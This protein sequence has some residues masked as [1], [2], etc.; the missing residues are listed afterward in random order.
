MSRRHCPRQTCSRKLHIEL[1]K[2]FNGSDDADIN[3]AISGLKH[4]ATVGHFDVFNE[5]DL[6]R[7][8]PD[9]V[10]QDFTPFSGREGRNKFQRNLPQLCESAGEGQQ[11]RESTDGL[12]RAERSRQRRTQQWRR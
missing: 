1:V 2:G 4:M 11:Q 3:G 12:E 10:I 6:L 5:S 8:L 7:I 9:T